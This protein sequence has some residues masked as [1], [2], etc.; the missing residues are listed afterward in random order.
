LFFTHKI[1][2]IKIPDNGPFSD[3][4]ELMSFKVANKRANI[5][6]CQFNLINSTYFNLTH[7]DI[8]MGYPRPG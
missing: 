7:P 5:N 3:P 2:I 4:P 6:G 1:L 8:A